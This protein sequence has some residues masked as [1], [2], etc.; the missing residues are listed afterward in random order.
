MM[1]GICITPTCVSLINFDFYNMWV[2]RDWLQSYLNK[3]LSKRDELIETVELHAF[4]VDDMADFGEDEVYE[5]DVLPNRAHDAL[6]HRGVARELAALLDIP[7]VDHSGGNPHGGAPATLTITNSE[8]EHCRR[9]SGRIINNIAVA[10]SPAWLVRRLESIGQRSVNNVVDILNY[11]MF[12]MGEPMHAFDLDRMASSEIVVRHAEDGEQMTTLTGDELTL[13]SDDLVIADR[14]KV[15]GLAGVKGGNAAETTMNTTNVVLEA[16]NFDPKLTRLSAQRHNQPTDAAKRFEKDITPRWTTEALERATGLILDICGTENTEVEEITDSNHARMEDITVDLSL[17]QVEPLLGVAV[18]ADDIEDILRRLGFSYTRNGQLFHVTPLHER[19]DIRIPEDLI[20][21]IGR[22]RGYG[23]IEPIVPHGADDAPVNKEFYYVTK[24][25]HALREM[26]YSEIYTSSF[27]PEGLGA[28]PVMNPLAEGK[29]AMRTELGAN[30]RDA[31]ERN[32]VYADL[33]ARDAVA[34][35]EVGTVF[36]EEHEHTSLCIGYRLKGKDKKGVWKERVAE[37]RDAIATILGGEIH[38]EPEDNVLEINLT[39]YIEK[40]DEP[41]AYDDLELSKDKA[42]RAYT[43]ISPYPP[44]YRDIAV[45]TPA[46]AGGREGAHADELV[47]IITQYG[48]DLM[49]TE[50]KCFDVFSKEANDGT[51]YTS[52]AYRLVFQSPERTLS[53]EEVNEIMEKIYTEV[54]EKGWTVR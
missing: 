34:L 44:V 29:E 10:D 20:E 27:V 21:E 36:G 15:L 22:I 11:V 43:P 30:I 42:D 54:E 49:V 50:P 31:L 13:T 7:F 5:L 24:I 14:K 2:S 23:E 19:L 47:N 53:D 41:K 48:G 51:T 3:P 9:Y 38:N 8:P 46:C 18:S 32:A 45:W 40:A 26:G 33:L 28:H 25:R 35:F 17:G 39:K 52:Y 12:D 1:F 4:E 6:C 37:A 16:A